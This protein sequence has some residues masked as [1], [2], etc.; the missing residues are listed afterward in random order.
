MANKAVTEKDLAKFR[1]HTNGMVALITALCIA[2]GVGIVALFFIL[3]W[4]MHLRA[5]KYA[6]LQLA[7]QDSFDSRE[8]ALLEEGY[9]NAIAFLH[10][11]MLSSANYMMRG[12]PYLCKT[13]QQSYPNPGH[14]DITLCWS[15]REQFPHDPHAEPPPNNPYKWYWFQFNGYAMP[16]ANWPQDQYWMPI[17]A[18]NPDPVTIMKAEGRDYYM[19]HSNTVWDMGIGHLPSWYINKSIQAAA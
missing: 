9:D 3:P 19:R 12:K 7:Y 14:K 17:S 2:T 15:L 4:Y 10:R 11:T 1:N 13:C 16:P 18:A 6:E 5:Q 8:L